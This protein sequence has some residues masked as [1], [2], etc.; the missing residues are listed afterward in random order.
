MERENVVPPLQPNLTSILK[1]EKHSLKS[2]W[3]SVEKEIKENN[4]SY[5]LINQQKQDD[6]AMPG[7]RTLKPLEQSKSPKES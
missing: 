7:N 1:M 6:I 4:L 3:F 5:Y 2:K